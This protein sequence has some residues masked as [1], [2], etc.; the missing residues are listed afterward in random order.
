MSL[1]P[2]ARF[3]REEQNGTRL[4][5]P[6]MIDVLIELSKWFNTEFGI[7]RKDKFLAIVKG[8]PPDAKKETAGSFKPSDG[9]AGNDLEAVSD[10]N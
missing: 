3:S 8:H 1:P 9:P 4:N 5:A 6:C 2:A 10:W 7:T